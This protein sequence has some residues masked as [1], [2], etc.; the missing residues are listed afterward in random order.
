[1]MIIVV[2]AIASMLLTRFNSRVFESIKADRNVDALAQAKMGL[3]SWAGSHEYLGGDIRDGDGV[4]PERIS[5]SIRIS[6]GHLTKSLPV[7]EIRKVLM[8]LS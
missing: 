2:A 6:W 8:S 4:S 7:D 1:M 5:G 3:V